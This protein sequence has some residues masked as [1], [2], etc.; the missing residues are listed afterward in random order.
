MNYMT[1]GRQGHREDAPTLTLHVT[2]TTRADKK[3]SLTSTNA[4]LQWSDT[5][6][7]TM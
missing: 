2:D 5:S 1:K 3:D 4:D 7:Q 6:N